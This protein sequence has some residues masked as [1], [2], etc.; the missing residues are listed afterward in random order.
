MLTMND[1]TGIAFTL[2]DL[3]LM[4]LS[5]SAGAKDIFAQQPGR[6]LPPSEFGRDS[7]RQIP[8]RD[9]SRSR[10]HRESAGNCARLRRGTGLRASRLPLES[11]TE[12]HHRK[13]SR[14]QDVPMNSR[15][16]LKQRAK[17]NTTAPARCGTIEKH[18]EGR[19]S[20]AEER[21]F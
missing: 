15:R 11:G 8:A 7:G 14:P 19:R 18:L 12:R 17:S 2:T 10:G 6:Q 21:R 9:Q 20:C 5:I 3:V 16:Y 4:G 13:R 1:R